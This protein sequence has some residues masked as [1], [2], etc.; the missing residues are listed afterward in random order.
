[1]GVRLFGSVLFKDIYN[2]IDVEFSSPN[3]IRQQ[4]YTI[5]PGG[6]LND[7]RFLVEYADDLKINEKG[8]LVITTREGDITFGLQVE[9]NG[10]EIQ[11][12]FVLQKKEE[13]KPKTKDKIADTKGV[14]AEFTI[15]LKGEVNTA[16]PY[17]VTLIER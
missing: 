2:N 7:M 13:P 8:D 5:R 3:S 15:Q 14:T 6:N 17:T 4:V 10:Q 12:A 11:S 1:M 9:Q 16:A